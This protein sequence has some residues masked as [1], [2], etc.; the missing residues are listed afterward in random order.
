MTPVTASR[1]LAA[2]DGVAAELLH[3]HG[4]CRLGR[5]PRR[6]QRF[7]RLARSVTFQQL[8]GAAAGTIWGRVVEAVDADAPTPAA[9]LAAGT[10]RLRAAGLSAAKAETLV[11][12]ARAVDSGALDLAALDRL[13]DHAVID[14]LT[15]IRGIGPWTA[16]M[17]LLFALHRLDV[18]PVGDAG[19][20][21]G[22]ACIHDL[23]SVPTREQ[24]DDAGEPFRPYRSV[25]AWWCWRE[26]D[27]TPA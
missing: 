18:W 24:L 26:A 5:R 3:R 15:A 6:D 25:L 9:V 13:P 27:A 4:P 16:Q 22:Y 12:L 23:D 7:A 14:E 19:V 2:R 8:S 17:F 11:E 10:A 1:T 20:R 21:R